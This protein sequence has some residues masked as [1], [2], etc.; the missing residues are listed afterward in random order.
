LKWLAL[1]AALVLGVVVLRAEPPPD[2]EPIAPWPAKGESEG[3]VFDGTQFVAFR[4]A[5]DLAIGPF[6]ISVWVKASDLAGGD[7]TYGRG[8]ARSTR[9]EKVG[10]WLLSV[11]P[12]GKVRFC[13]WRKAG[14]DETGSHVT[15][16][17]LIDL[18]AW[19]QIVA[20][21]DGKTNHIFVNGVEVKYT[22]STTASGWETG[23]EV[24]RSWTQ[25]GYYWAGTIHDLRIY[26]KAPAAADILA[27]FKSDPRSQAPKVVVTPA[28]D[29]KVSEAIDRE[30]LAK[31]KQQNVGAA[32]AADDAEF[33]RRVILDLAGRI[34]TMAETEA[35]LADS[36]PDKRQKL[37]DTFLSGREMPLYWS[38]VLS[39]WLMPAENRRD[40]KFVGYLRTGLANNKS[41]DRFVREMLLARPTGP[42]DQAASAFLMSRREALK[43]NTIA[44]D[45]GRALFGVNLRCAQCHDHPHVPEWTR[46]HFMGLSAFFARS[47]EVTYTNAG[48]QPVVVLA[49][50]ATGE[51]E[52]PT[53]KGK[54]V[55]RLMF[56]DGK[57][58]N[59]PS[60]EKPEVQNSKLEIRNPKEA[61]PVPPFSRREALAN[62]ALDPKSPYVKRAIVNRVWRQ[63]MGRALVEPVDMMSVANTA[64]HPRLLDLLA[65]D[66]ANHGFDLRRLIAV[67]LHSEAYARSS[68]WPGRKELPDETLYAVAVLKPLDADQLALSLPLATGHY[69]DQLSGTPKRT[70]AQLR[71]VASWPDVIAQFDSPSEDFEPTAV[72]ALFLLNSDYVQKHFVADSK[73]VKTL[74]ADKSDDEVARRAYRAILSRLPSPDETARVS[75]YLTDRGAKSRTDACQELVWALFSGPE[76]RFNH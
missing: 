46:Q 8:I 19:Y 58:I 74:V 51:L 76:F 55:A 53:A 21:W 2:K 24:G 68:R 18:D 27:D 38:Q 65:D 62:A 63:L 12:D 72:Q 30:I 75:K 33:H 31:L 56:L 3:Q 37:I 15:V 13:N 6:A 43:D 71:G 9:A 61:P 36:S 60:A 57:A 54:K 23:H 59:E 44:R 25:P 50:K 73:L 64:S 48:N 26:R 22:D 47:Y 28:G 45:V 66:F 14:A 1:G 11:H 4:A 10:D 69:D 49:E 67:I 5:P 42:G 39:S 16:D 41:W 70:M 29:A 52:Y 7:P 32:P 34:P 35:F 40:P 20:T 17:G